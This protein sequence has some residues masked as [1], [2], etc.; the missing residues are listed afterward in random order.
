MTENNTEDINAMNADLEVRVKGFNEELIP[1]LGKYKVGLGAVAFL[2]PD[3]SVAARPQLFDDKKKE[4][5]APAE[6]TGQADTT[7]SEA[8][9]VT[10]A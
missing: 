2:T 10:E 8:S 6:S 5:D 7:A 3:G 4:A 1:L 9:E